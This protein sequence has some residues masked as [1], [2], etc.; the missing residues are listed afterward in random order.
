MNPDIQNQRAQLNLWWIIWAAMLASLA[1]VWGACGFRQLPGGGLPLHPL[2]QV[3]GLVPLFLS[4]VI[5]WLMLPRYTDLQR[6]FVLYLAGLALAE[7]CGLLGI[8][9]GGPYRDDVFMLGLMGIVQ[10]MPFF[11]R[12][13]LE[14]KP[15]GFIPNN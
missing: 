11:A 9:L 4:I 12:K 14:P 3:A 6:A 2:V 7:G 1:L 15:E 8:F 5:R 10:F 13:Y